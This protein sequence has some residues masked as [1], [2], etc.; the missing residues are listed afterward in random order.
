MKLT[1]SRS[2]GLV[3]LLFGTLGASMAS[4]PICVSQKTCVP[5][6]IDNESGQDLY[7]EV[8]SSVTNQ[9]FDFTHGDRYN[10]TFS[11]TDNLKK[12]SNQKQEMIY[13]PGAG[14][15]GGAR[16]YLAT[17]PMDGVP[18]LATA[19]YIYDKIEMG[20]NDDLAG[21]NTT[22]VDFFGM[23]INL[24]NKD[25]DTKQDTTVG[26]QDGTKRSAVISEL[27]T[28][29]GKES[30]LYDSRFFM[31]SSDQTLLRVFSPLHFYT[32]LPDKWHNSIT[33][34]LNSL[35]TT[36]SSFTY[37]GNQYTNFK[38]LSDSSVSIDENSKTVVLSGITTGNAA[39]GQIAPVGDQFAGM[40]SAA[41][42]RGVLGSPS[43]WGENGGDNQGFPNDYYQGT[44]GNYQFNTY[45]KV[46]LDY[47]ID[48]KLYATSYDDFWHMDSSIHVGA[49]NNS[50][51]TVKILSLN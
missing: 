7:A 43:K 18:D 27:Q 40:L 9:Y 25:K 3:I 14:I 24:T 11:P 21:W 17:Q 28:E 50:P 4:D 41:I 15:S 20:W 46:L 23:P 47:A 12:V 31:R 45:A 51:V 29:M 36:F 33:A 13:L 32:S 5:V 30:E 37:G 42:N 26:F 39:S 34:G 49:A 6:I 19:P 38:K 44:T 8:H 22:S 2:I 48:H 16:M 35:T 1:P 10:S